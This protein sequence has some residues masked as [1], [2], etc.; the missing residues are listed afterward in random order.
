[1]EKQIRIGE[2]FG[3]YVEFST[4]LARYEKEQFVNFIHAAGRADKQNADLGFKFL[5]LKC[6]LSGQHTK[7]GHTRQTSTYKHGC[8]SYIYVVNKVRNNVP[9]LEVVSMNN[10]HN[11][12]VDKELFLHMPKQRKMAIESNK[13]HLES[14]LSVKPNMRSV[15]K[16]VNAPNDVGVVLLKDLRNFKATLKGNTHQNDL[17]Q[18]IEEMVKIENATVKVMHNDDMEIDCIFFQDQRMKLFFDQYPEL[19]M[20]DGTYKLNDRR[21]PLIVMLVVDGNGESQIAGLCVAK[22]ENA[23]TLRNLFHEFKD[24]NPNHTKIEVI[25]SDKSFASRNAFQNEFPHAKHQLCVFHVLQIF[26]REITTHKRKCTQGQREQA[27]KILKKMVYARSV[28]EYDQLYRNLRRINCPRVIEYFD[29]NWH[30]IKE[31]WVGYEVNK[32]ANFENRT[33]N[34]LESLNQK[35]KAVVSKYARLATF[36]DDL[37]TCIASYN[38]ERDHAAA[39]G[40]MKSILATSIDTEYDTKYSKILTQYAYHKY[41]KQSIKSERVEFT[42]IDE[43]EA[44]CM[45]NN[46]RITVSDDTCSCAFFNTMKL[47]CAHIIAFLVHHKEEAFKPTLCAERWKKDKSIFSKEFNY[48][49]V[50]SSSQQMIPCTNRPQRSRNMTA[51]E[52]FRCAEKV[53]KKICEIMSEKSQEDFNRLMVH[54]KQ[55]QTSLENNQFPVQDTVLEQRNEE[56]EEDF[57]SVQTSESDDSLL[58]DIVENVNEPIGSNSPLPGSSRS[59]E[60]QQ[61]TES[62]QRR[63]PSNDQNLPDLLELDTSSSSDNSNIVSTSSSGSQQPP[64]KRQSLPHGTSRIIRKKAQP[65]NSNKRKVPGIWKTNIHSTYTKLIEWSYVYT[66]FIFC[67]FIFQLLSISTKSAMLYL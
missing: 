12:K 28:T 24:E 44:E 14:V 21:M 13:L 1:M 49:A 22:S 11:H 46:V 67:D 32:F 41:K 45:E 29:S 2:R 57:Q 4:A 17:V 55:F 38:I 59:T 34:R 9:A 65:E 62:Q 54:L 50:P 63:D 40:I 25:M 42:R 7:T 56:V 6:K 36:F 51:N 8:M 47:P 53:T 61:T 23:R 31:Q 66:H 60:P 35:I 37:I 27:L 15:Q 16:Q 39:V 30:N 26:N 43:L 19:L 64:K 5:R 20:C 18:L 10:N 58:L 48:A 33:N 52:K 3:S